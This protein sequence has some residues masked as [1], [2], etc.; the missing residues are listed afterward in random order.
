MR[1]LSF[2][3][4]KGV[5]EEARGIVER[6]RTSLSSEIRKEL[7]KNNKRRGSIRLLDKG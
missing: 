1:V 4:E 2:K 3:V 5:A 7:E 6:Q